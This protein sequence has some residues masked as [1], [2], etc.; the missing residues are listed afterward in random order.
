MSIKKR[1]MIVEDEIIIAMELKS[2]L[3]KIGYLVPC[4]ETNYNDAIQSFKKELPDLILIDINL[5]NEKN[6]I[7]V[8]KDI[9]KIKETPFIYTTAF[10]DMQTIKKAVEQNPSS[11][12]VK[13]IKREELKI[14]LLLALNKT[15]PKQEIKN[16]FKN[17]C[18]YTG[19]YFDIDN[20]ILYEFDS[21]IKLSNN[22]KKFLKL[23]VESKN[24]I[25]YFSEI[26]SEIWP[27]SS[28]S[29]STLRTLIYRFKMKLT[30]SECIETIPLV[31]CKLNIL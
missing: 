8:A 4:I 29:D 13:P 1:I 22:E 3:E 17:Y 14:N 10:S 25:V 28:L 24:Q 26:K 16:D 9:N 7:D 23:L 18:L 5:R 6:G 30:N 12:L 19:C 21:I 11:Y 15:T 31:G 27:D 2:Y 20:E